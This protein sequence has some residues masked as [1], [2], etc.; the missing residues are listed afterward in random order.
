MSDRT[1]LLVHLRRLPELFAKAFADGP[2]GTLE[3]KFEAEQPIFTHY[4][5]AFY[6]AGC[7]AF[8]EGED[9]AYSWTKS[10]ASDPDFD[11]FVGHYPA[12]PKTAYGARGI[13]RAS[14]EA[15]A[16]IRNA[17]T[18]NAGDLSKNRNPQS[19]AIVAAA[20]LPGV[21]L[22]G[23]VVKLEAAFLGFVRVAALAVCNYHGEF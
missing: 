23:P 6:L 20:S 7:L 14:M 17:V 10:S 1:K 3:G 13:N 2:D 11:T 12:P 4:G 16:C 15:L 8:L 19:V 21:T 18:H 22:V 5:C 9:G